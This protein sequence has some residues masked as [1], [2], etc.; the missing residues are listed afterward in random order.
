MANRG[1][2]ALR[3][4]QEAM[5][6]VERVARRFGFLNEVAASELGNLTSKVGCM[7]N[8]RRPSLADARRPTPG[9]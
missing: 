6:L 7:L 8:A 3:V 4:W 9:G 5:A 2:Q 1:P